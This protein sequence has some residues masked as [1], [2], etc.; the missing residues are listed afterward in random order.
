MTAPPAQEL[1]TVTTAVVAFAGASTLPG[2]GRTSASSG[3]A[4]PDVAYIWISN[5]VSLFEWSAH[6]TW[7][8]VGPAP[9]ANTPDGAWGAVGGS[10]TAVAV[11][12]G[13]SP[14]WLWAVS[15]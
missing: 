8:W 4:A 11:T 7:I 6:M 2:S 10:V 3:R 5:P 15:R 12:A 9:L 1:G 14:A 13:A